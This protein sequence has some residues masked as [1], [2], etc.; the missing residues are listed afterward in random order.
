MPLVLA[1]ANLTDD[2]FLSAFEACG[3]PLS[4]FRHAD[5]LRLAWLHL[6]RTSL[7]EAELQVR[8]GIKRFAERHGILHIY[9]DTVTTAW[10]RLLSTHR[11]QSFA[12]F[13]SIHEYRLNMDLLHR[14]WTP[15]LLASEPA[16]RS[17]VAPD[18][19]SLPVSV[20]RASG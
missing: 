13:L 4:G 14:F 6:H 9:H 3:L 17:W 2:E 15:E 11:E 16:R 20:L 1:S 5:H 10:V 12:E 18:R 7:A 8:N 19:E